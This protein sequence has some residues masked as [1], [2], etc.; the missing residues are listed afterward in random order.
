MIHNL[1][2]HGRLTGWDPQWFDGFPLYVFYFPLP[3]LLVAALSVVFPYA[4]A[5]KLV[6]VLGTVTLPVLRMGIRLPGRVPQ[7]SADPDGRRQC[8][9]TCSTRPTRSTAATSPRRWPGEFSFSLSMSFG[10]LFLGVFV[11]ALRTGRLRWLAAVLFAATVLCHIV[12]GF[13]FAA[14]AILLA[15]SMGRLSAFRVL[16][17]V[18]IVGGLSGGVLAAAVRRRTSTTALRWATTGSSASGR[19]HPGAESLVAG[20]RCI[21]PA[22]IGLVIACRPP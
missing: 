16:I 8:S 4:V 19:P 2:N 5:F 17:P 11:Y 20:L 21:G 13:A 10:M 6:T 3:A 14:M 18:G 12:P 7:T 15:L 1:L 22:A 9:P